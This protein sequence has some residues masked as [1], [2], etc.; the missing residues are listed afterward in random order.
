MPLALGTAAVPFA[1]DSSL[2][3]ATLHYGSLGRD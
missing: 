2:L 3:L 1:V